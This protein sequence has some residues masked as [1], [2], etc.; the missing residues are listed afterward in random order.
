MHMV[1]SNSGAKTAANVV[2]WSQNTVTQKSKK[3]KFYLFIPTNDPA[4]AAFS[5]PLVL[6]VTH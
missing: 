5:G 6:V 3:N 2:S 4:C 1:A